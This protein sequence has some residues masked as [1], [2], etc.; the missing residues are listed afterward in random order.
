MIMI[1][2]GITYGKTDASHLHHSTLAE[3]FVCENEIVEQILCCAPLRSGASP[4]SM[5][6]IPTSDWPATGGFN[7]RS[8]LWP[9]TVLIA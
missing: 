6:D 9:L 4:P 7:W 2:H 5:D 3:N 1:S 8:C